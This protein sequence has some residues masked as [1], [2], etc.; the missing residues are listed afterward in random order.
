VLTRVLEKEDPRT[1]VG[2]GLGD[3]I[4]SE[5]GR[6]TGA[7]GGEDVTV[8]VET[9]CTRTGVFTSVCCCCSC[10]ATSRICSLTSLRTD[11]VAIVA[12]SRRFTSLLCRREE[13]PEEM[14][15]T[16]F[17]EEESF[18]DA[19]GSF[20]SLMREG[21]CDEESSQAEIAAAVE[22]DMAREVVEVV[23]AEEEEAEAEEVEGPDLMRRETA[24]VVVEVEGVEAPEGTAEEEEMRRLP[25]FPASSAATCCNRVRSSLASEES[26]A[27]FSKKALR[28]LELVSDGG[29]CSI[30]FESESIL[31]T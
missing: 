25:N 4:R 1:T 21:G 29:R 6:G 12:L 13:S 22:E 24:V 19:G 11:S 7:A 8:V 16:L 31:T 26:L 18:H 20:S 23:A 2:C 10:F 27:S 9:G 30:Q 5:A 14:A 15:R 3:G 17:V 28:S